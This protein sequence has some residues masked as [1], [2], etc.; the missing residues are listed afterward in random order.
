MTHGQKLRLP[1]GTLQVLPI[2]GE[3]TVF[4]VEGAG[5]ECTVC[6]RYYKRWRYRLNYST[7]YHEPVARRGRQ[8]GDP[9]PYRRGCA[10]KL[11]RRWHRVDIL[12][13]GGHGGCA[14]EKF[15]LGLRVELSK[16]R[17]STW[18]EGRFRCEHIDE[19]R[20]FAVDLAIRMENMERMRPYANGRRELDESMA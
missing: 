17:P 9:C 18:V 3:R 12:S 6:G 10:G 4:V 19:A 1:P 2:P 5:V 8:A 20:T 15:D 14:C 13:W 16:T 11:D 7:G